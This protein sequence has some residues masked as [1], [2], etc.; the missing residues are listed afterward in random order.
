MPMHKL[1]ISP[2]V[3]QECK[4]YKDRLTMSSG[5]FSCR[6][7]LKWLRDEINNGNA[8]AIN[9]KTR[10]KKKLRPKDKSKYVQYLDVIL[11]EYENL[12]VCK[13]DVFPAYERTF[14]GILGTD[15][16]KIKI[17]Y[18]KPKITKKGTTY[19]KAK[20]RFYELI[21]E[22]MDY[23]K[24]QS[25]VFP[26]V[27]ENL[28]I[29]TCVY[30]NAQ[31]A[32]AAD[33]TTAL[34]QLDHCLPKSTH[35][36]L[37]TSFY[38]LQPSCG[39]CNQR[40]SSTDI[41]FGTNKEYTLSMWQ[42]PT[43][44]VHEDFFNFHIDDTQ[45]A[46]Y[47]SAS[48]VHDPKMLTLQYLQRSSAT[49]EEKDLLAKVEKTFHITDLYNKQLDIVEETVWRYRIYS[50]GYM[51]S[52]NNAMNNLFPDMKGQVRRLVLGTYEGEEN[53]YR[54]P[55]TKMIHDIVKQISAKP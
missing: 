21:V 5:E 13:P 22:L 38:N 19:T 26:T 48:R 49:Q 6:K 54:R 45:L 37:C 12:L 17:Q 47:L 20:V 8:K 46:K 51:R 27:L 41:R 7:D 34:Y 29:K 9:T 15:D 53:T 52:L 50:R 33:E 31:F 1:E 40:K 25:T 4:K 14:N 10:G 43:D 36:Y 24:V 35:P 3:E 28:N 44:P 55:M 39:S 11:S 2:S 23:S 30:C 42:I 16:L 18:N 32:I